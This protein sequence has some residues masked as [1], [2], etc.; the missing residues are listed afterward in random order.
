MTH[1]RHGAWS[2]SKAASYPVILPGYLS[3]AIRRSKFSLLKSHGVRG[4]L[5]I[6]PA[7]LGGSTLTSPVL[8]GCKHTHDPCG[9]SPAVQL[10]VTVY[11]SGAAIEKL[12]AV[13]ASQLAVTV[14]CFR[15]GHREIMC[16]AGLSVHRG[17]ICF[18][19][20]HRETVCRA[21]RGED[22]GPGHPGARRALPPLQRHQGP[23][24]GRHRGGQAA[25]PLQGQGQL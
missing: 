7:H 17:G 19:R 16:R 4:Q 24:A 10:A 13:Q 23:P 25:H 18:R 5:V 8:P 15:R 14:I 9:A 12:C 1:I 22:H 21:G 2:G 3:G 6:S 11:V 20:G